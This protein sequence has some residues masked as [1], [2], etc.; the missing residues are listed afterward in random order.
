MS[1][2]LATPDDS[3]PKIIDRKKDGEMEREKEVE[4]GK[5]GE[6]KVQK[7]TAVIQRMSDSYKRIESIIQFRFA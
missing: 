5:G 6:R 2:R 7:M 4:G 1:S 3:R